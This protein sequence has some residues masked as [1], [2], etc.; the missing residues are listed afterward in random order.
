MVKVRSMAALAPARLH[1]DQVMFD[2]PQYGVA[3]GQAA[4]AYVDNRLVAGGTIAATMP[5]RLP[6][7]Q[8]A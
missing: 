1:G 3:P 8:L 7:A 2:A 4:V 5:A 6:H